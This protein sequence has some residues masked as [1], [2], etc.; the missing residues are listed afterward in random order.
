MHQST[1]AKVQLA[2]A[3]IELQSSSVEEDTI[4]TLE[5]RARDN[6]VLSRGTRGAEW[7]R[8][9]PISVR[10]GGNSEG[11]TS[12]FSLSDTQKYAIWGGSGGLVLLC[13]CLCMM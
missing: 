9:D 11:Q 1:L 8:M 10:I 3:N 12:S 5:I 4:N 13:C 6:S 2:L 7:I